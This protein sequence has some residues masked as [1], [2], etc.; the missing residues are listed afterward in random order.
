MIDRDTSPIAPNF[1]FPDL[2]CGDQKTEFLLHDL[3]QKSEEFS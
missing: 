2:F 1:R 3:L